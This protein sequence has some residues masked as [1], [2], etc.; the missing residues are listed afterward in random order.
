MTNRGGSA[1]GGARL[2]RALGLELGGG[3]TCDDVGQHDSTEHES[4]EHTDADRDSTATSTTA[5]EAS[6][7]EG[8]HAKERRT[9]LLLL[10]SFG[11]CS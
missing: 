5:A 4:A 8:P 3:G 9:F 7:A 2:A 6:A 1:G 11:D 10:L